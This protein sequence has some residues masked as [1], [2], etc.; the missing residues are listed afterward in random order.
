MIFYTQIVPVT[1]QAGQ[2][3]VVVPPPQMQVLD[4]GDD[5]V[6][7]QGSA[8]VQHH[9]LVGPPKQTKKIMKMKKNY[10]IEK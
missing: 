7:G 6:L 9:V 3:V 10:F 4:V 5:E 1:D 2:Q 8:A